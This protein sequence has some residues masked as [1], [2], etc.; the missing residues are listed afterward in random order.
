MRGGENYGLFQDLLSLAIWLH[1][2]PG[3]TVGDIAE[4]FKV[5]R[6]TAERMR[7]TM[8][9]FFGT[10]FKER[11][12][13]QNKYYWIES[14]RLDPLI[15]NSVTDS[16]LA[17][18]SLAAKVLE[19]GG[20][21]EAA[22]SVAALG[23]KIGGLMTRGRARRIDLEDL[24]RTEGLAMRPGP[25]IRYDPGV[26]AAIREAM[27]GFRQLRVVYKGRDQVFEADLIPLGVL[28][29]ERRHYLVGRYSDGWTT[30]P[31]HFILDKIIEISVLEATF[32]EDPD[33]SLRAHAR[34]SFG[35][36]QEEQFDVEWLFSPGVAD[37]ASHFLF[38]PTQ[39]SRLNPDGS[40]TVKFRCGG[41]LEMSWHLH[42]WGGQVRVVKPADFWQSL[43][44]SC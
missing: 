34:Q 35:A 2:S 17:S 20:M 18:L 39:T 16:E 19:Q 42:T 12:E 15:M 4:R 11:R 13:G 24:L 29:G 22:G 25:V 36:F 14:R 5:A 9:G 8:A 26:L 27:L 10:A 40:L 1:G 41:R 44:D 7:D 43:R 33:F 23:E 6:R 21:T 28:Y 3:V 32:E 38:H 30:K 37:E 31:R